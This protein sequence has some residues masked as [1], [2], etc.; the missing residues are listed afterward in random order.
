MFNN[1]RNIAFVGN[2]YNKR[3]PELCICVGRDRI[4]VSA[5][6]RITTMLINEQLHQPVLYPLHTADYVV[7]YTIVCGGS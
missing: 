5:T 1:I 6:T 2:I 3:V 4:L 7:R